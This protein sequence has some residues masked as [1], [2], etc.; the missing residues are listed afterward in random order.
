MKKVALLT[1]LLV[2]G[3]IYTEQVNSDKTLLNK[4]RSMKT[5]EEVD[6]SM[7][8]GEIVFGK[9]LFNVIFRYFNDIDPEVLAEIFKQLAFKSIC[10]DFNWLNDGSD[11]RLIEERAQEQVNVYTSVVSSIKTLRSMMQPNCKVSQ[12]PQTFVQK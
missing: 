4:L 11:L 5:N 9:D 3:K 8:N 12:Q 10:Y 1:I 6:Q 2:V 7:R